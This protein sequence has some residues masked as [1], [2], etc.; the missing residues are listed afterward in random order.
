MEKIELANLPSLDFEIKNSLPV[1]LTDFTR[2]LLALGDEFK[3][4]IADEEPEA[5][6]GDLRLYVKEIRSGSII[7]ALAAASPQIMQGV[8]YVNTVGGFAK[9]L[10]VAYDW[11]TGKSDD[12]PNL[13]KTS[14][15]NLQTIVEPIAKDRAAQLNINAPFGQVYLNLN[16]G[17]ANAAQNAARREIARLDE[18]GTHHFNNVLLYWY[19]ARD[20]KMS[21]TG[22][23][24]I[25]ES[26]SKKPVRVRW[27]ND[28]IKAQ[29]LHGNENPFEEAYLVDVMV[30][31]IQ[32]KPKVYLV[33]AVHDHFPRDDD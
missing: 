12:Q 9:Y 5:A 13:D 2:S 7:G 6:A 11:L 21:K 17:D 18:T 27:A 4:Y 28:G 8:G 32:G 24:G 3:R 14:Y 25:I 22:D 26:V 20:D 31:T 1:E 19:Q 30:Q 16:S 29:L 33:L 10:K 23:K 15:E